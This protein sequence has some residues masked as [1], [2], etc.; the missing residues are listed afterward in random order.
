MEDE[1]SATLA[2]LPYLFRKSAYSPRTFP[3]AIWPLTWTSG[4]LG[5]KA[6]SKFGHSRPNATLGLRQEFTSLQL[7]N[8]GWEV[9]GNEQESYHLFWG[10]S[11]EL[12]KPTMLRVLLLI[13]GKSSGAWNKVWPRASLDAVAAVNTSSFLPSSRHLVFILRSL[14]PICTL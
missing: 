2:I 8:P 9:H 5:S 12:I 3:A 7:A 14:Y 6:D 10:L 4:L 13:W 11:I 1:G